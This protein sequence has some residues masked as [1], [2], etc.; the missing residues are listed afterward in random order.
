MIRAPWGEMAVT[1]WLRARW[2][3]WVLLLAWMAAIYQ[4]S[5]TPGLKTV[6]IIQRLGLLPDSLTPWAL[7]LLEWVLR[8]S[9]H[10]VSFGILALLADGALNGR[11]RAWFFTLGYAV[12]DE[13]HQTFVPSRVGSPLDVVID[14]AGA[15]LFLL[16]ASRSNRR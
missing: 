8:K 5:D 2:V 11:W 10:F 6:P 16:L 15:L 9:A 14:S 12:L 7:D 3:R 1:R 13:I 4:A